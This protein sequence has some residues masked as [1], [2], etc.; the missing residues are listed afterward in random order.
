[1]KKSAFT[2]IEL[3]VVISIIAILA[4]I[5]LP[6]FGG[7]MGRARA[8]QSA[9]NLRQLGLGVQAYLND[10]D[11]V[12]VSGTDTFVVTTTGSDGLSKYVPGANVWQA[13][14]DR[15]LPAT[16]VKFPV[17]FSFN[18]GILGPPPGKTVAKGE[19]NG[20]LGMIKS[21]PSSI[22]MMAPNY[23]LGSGNPEEKASWGT[24][25]VNIGS[26]VK[27][28]PMG[29]GNIGGATDKPKAFPG[30]GKQIPVLFCDGHIGNVAI[31]KAM[32]AGTFR[33]TALWDPMK[34]VTLT[35]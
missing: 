29:G 28:I 14:L 8:T 12:M 2:L 19:W 22:V 10:N 20:D 16:G 21:S 35:P 3:L 33:D 5:A 27:A 4:G 15:R 13:P 7:V 24:D 34:A 1:M 26:S 25:A 17:S 30:M 32:T 23:Q 18:Q 11:S 6:V 31:V 9:S